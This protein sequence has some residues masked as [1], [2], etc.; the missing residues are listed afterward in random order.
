[1]EDSKAALSVI[2]EAL[3]AAD[4]QPG[5]VQLLNSLIRQCQLPD[6]LADLIKWLQQRP[7]LTVPGAEEQHAP[8]SSCAPYDTLWDLSIMCLT[9]LVEAVGSLEDGETAGT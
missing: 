5:V 7:E 3:D 9:H 4:S 1:M 8:D 6:V 2:R